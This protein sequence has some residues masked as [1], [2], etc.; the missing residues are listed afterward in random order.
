MQATL[1]V[2]AL[3]QHG[4]R[5]VLIDDNPTAENIAKLIYNHARCWGCRSLRSGCGKLHH[6][7]RPIMVTNQIT[8]GPGRAVSGRSQRLGR[9]RGYSVHCQERDYTSP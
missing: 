6:L 8:S 3:K 2:P 9:G 5:F 4:E 7:V 1:L